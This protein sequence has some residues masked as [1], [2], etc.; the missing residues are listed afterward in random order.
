MS[1]PSKESHRQYRGVSCRAP[2]EER[3][4]STLRLVAAQGWDAAHSAKGKQS[5]KHTTTLT[6]RAAKA[7]TASDVHPVAPSP[8]SKR[9]R[10]AATHW[11]KLSLLPTG[12]QWRK[13]N[14]IL[15]QPLTYANVLAQMR[16]RGGSSECCHA[17]ESS[18]S[19]SISKKKRCEILR[20]SPQGKLPK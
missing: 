15:A 13:S 2:T 3:H 9:Y 10:A 7:A 17:F 4:S 18:R 20:P 6:P 12:A 14:P 1:P 8:S 11:Q 19:M 5:R 16:R